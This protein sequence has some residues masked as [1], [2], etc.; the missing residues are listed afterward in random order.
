MFD[1]TN[2]KA[3]IT[4][5]SQGIGA[6]IA[7][8]FAKQGATVFIHGSSSAEKCK[9]IADKIGVNAKIAVADLSNDDCAEK[10]YEQT[11]DIDILVLN[12]SIQFRKA[13]NE[14]TLD[15]FKKQID[16]N[17]RAS[18][19]LVQKYAPKMLENR[20]GRIV[21]VGSVQQFKPHKD[22]AV[23]AASKEAQISLMK[24]LAKQFAPYG[25]TVN[26]LAPGVILTPRN[27]TALADEE[28]AKKVYEG[29]PAG[30]AGAPCDCAAAAL[31]LCSDEG[32]YIIG[33]DLVVDGG[34][35]L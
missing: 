14:I 31:L 28:Y 27:D 34:M 19:Q 11:G 3:L 2:K 23:Y 25:V 26:G 29:I 12:A 8:C 20:Y 7:E 24:N 32:R 16:V 5:S 9:R 17:L 21:F 30:F 15:E 1:L 4:G 6:S 33:N 18:L 35:H 22:M 13:W 10:L